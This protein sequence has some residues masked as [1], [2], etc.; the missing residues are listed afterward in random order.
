MSRCDGRNREEG[1][2]GRGN[3][4]ENS[5]RGV[6]HACMIYV[7]VLLFFKGINTNYFYISICM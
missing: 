2:H 1:A 6:M 5:L 7:Q 4:L 3:L